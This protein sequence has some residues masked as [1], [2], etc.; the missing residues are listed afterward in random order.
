MS[1]GT[2]EDMTTDYRPEG[3]TSLTPFVVVSPAREAVEFYRDVFDARVTS[4]VDGPDG[5]VMH[6]EL[7]FGC[8]RL[9]L[10]DPAEQFHTVANDPSTDETTFSIGVYVSDVDEVTERARQRGARVREEPTDFEVTGDRFSSIQDPFGVRWSIMTRVT[11]H[12]DEEIQE[13]LDAWVAATV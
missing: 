9:Q 4:R 6:A 3:F 10:M 13:R 8:G 7:D 12:T 1:L 5:T 11:P 2:I